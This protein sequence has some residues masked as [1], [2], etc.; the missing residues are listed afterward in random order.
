MRPL[1]LSRGLSRLYDLFLQSLVGNLR[2]LHPLSDSCLHVLVLIGLPL[3]VVPEDL[4]LRN[5]DFISPPLLDEQRSLSMLGFSIKTC[6]LLGVSL[7]FNHLCIG[8]K[9]LA[10]HG[11][12]L[13]LTLE[14][15][16]LLFLCLF[17]L[18]Q[19]FSYLLNAFLTMF[20]LLLLLNHLLLSHE[21]VANLLLFSCSLPNLGHHMHLLCE[22]FLFFDFL[23]HLPF[24]LLLGLLLT[25]RSDNFQSLSQLCQGHFFKQTLAWWLCRVEHLEALHRCL[26]QGADLPDEILPAL[27]LLLIFALFPFKLSFFLFSKLF[28]VLKPRLQSCLLGDA[29]LLSLLDGLL[30]NDLL[31]LELNLEL[32]LLLS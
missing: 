21:V 29:R 28:C 12:L 5:L 7:S 16:L 20:L 31:V 22:L 9:E 17:L 18:L 25:L 11:D 27:H 30:D 1:Q 4:S 10:L 2:T 23:C 6:M 14:S 26:L 8:C 15:H 32:L 3:L 13:E 19:L 24:P